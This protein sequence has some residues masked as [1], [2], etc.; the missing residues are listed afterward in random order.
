M[1]FSLR[2]VLE[3]TT[4]TLLTTN[5]RVGTYGYM[6]ASVSVLGML[7]PGSHSSPT[8]DLTLRLAKTLQKLPEV[9]SPSSDF[10]G[11]IWNHDISPS[12]IILLFFFLLLL[13]F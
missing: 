8:G 9:D 10:P 7:R 13:L 6:Q 5:S 12:F 3:Q 1:K 2:N 4:S 11:K